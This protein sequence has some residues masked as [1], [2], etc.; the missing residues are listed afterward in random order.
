LIK[1]ISIPCKF[2]F[3]GN[4][5]KYESWKPYLKDIEVRTES[6]VVDGA[7]HGFVE[8]GTEEKLFG[9]TLKWINRD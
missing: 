8:D 7:S 5:D 4:C 3:A 9:E 2:I 1:K 6:V